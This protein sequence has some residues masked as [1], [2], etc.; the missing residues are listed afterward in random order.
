MGQRVKEVI[1]SEM[2]EEGQQEIDFNVSDLTT[3]IYIVEVRVNGQVIRS[4][5]SRF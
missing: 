4:M 1:S 2:L 5:L 3:G